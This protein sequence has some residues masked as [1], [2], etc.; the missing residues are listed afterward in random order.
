M[1]LQKKIVFLQAT[2]RKNGAFYLLQRALCG[3]QPVNLAIIKLL[4]L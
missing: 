2:F 4:T 1:K 3:V